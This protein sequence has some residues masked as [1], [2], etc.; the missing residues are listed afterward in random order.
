MELHYASQ[1]RVVPPCRLM[2]SS[3]GLTRRV[4][5][6]LAMASQGREDR[7]NLKS[8][9]AGPGSQQECL[10]GALN[11]VCLLSSTYSNV[12]LLRRNT[13]M[14]GALLAMPLRN[15]R[16]DAH[17]TIGDAARL[18]CS[19]MVAANPAIW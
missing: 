13:R 10:L 19:M 4:G 14:L 17:N 2:L 1:P 7:M 9:E 11:R 6:V 18:A 12:L 3:K 5:S 15:S 16:V 8:H